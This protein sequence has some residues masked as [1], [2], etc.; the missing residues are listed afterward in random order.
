MSSSLRP[1]RDVAAL[2]GKVGRRLSAP[3]VR[4][5]KQD[6]HA[7]PH[8]LGLQVRGH[9]SLPRA[10]NRRGRCNRHNRAVPVALV[11]QRARQ[12]GRDGQRRKAQ[13]ERPPDN[14]HTAHRGAPPVPVDKTCVPLPGR[15]RSTTAVLSRGRRVRLGAETSSIASGSVSS[16]AAAYSRSLKYAL[17]RDPARSPAC[18]ACVRHF[19]PSSGVAVASGK[20]ELL[21]GHGRGQRRPIANHVTGVMGQHLFADREPI[22]RPSPFVQ[23]ARRPIPIACRGPSAD[24]A[25]GWPERGANTCPAFG[26]LPP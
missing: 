7:C 10:T 22:F 13:H 11:H 1:A 3:L 23:P 20:S 12:D 8:G 9:V 18:A 2:P 17:V 4:L 15:C 26:P 16:S 6:R 19:L 24:G 14:E 25:Y 5:F 21:V